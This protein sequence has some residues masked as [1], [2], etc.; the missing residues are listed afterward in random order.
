MTTQ[1]DIRAPR[2]EAHGI[3][4]RYG[5]VEA[6]KGVTLTVGRGEILCLAG[7]NGSGK[8]TFSK[9][10]AGTETSD[11]GSFR[12]D[13][14]VIDGLNQKERMQA[15]IQMIYQDFSLFHNLTAAENIYLVK[16]SCE[17][18][19]RINHQIGR[20]EAMVALESIGV[21]INPDALVEDL[22]VGEKQ[23]VAI[24]RAIIQNAKLI[25]MDEPTTALTDPEINQLMKIVR[26][27]AAQGVSFISISHKLEEILNLTDRTVILRGGSL[28]LEADTETLDEH[29]ITRALIGRELPIA[30]LRK[31][32]MK[33]GAPLLE[34]RGLRRE[35][36]FG[37]IDLTIEQGEIVGLGGRLG[38]GRTALALAL[39]GALR[40]DGG[41]FFLDG[42]QVNI[43]SIPDALRR[44]IAYL[45]EDRLTEGLFLENSIAENV[46]IPVLPKEAGRLGAL[47]LRR[48]RQLS[49]EWVRK[50]DIA[51]PSV[52]L[53]ARSLSGGNQQRVVLA[54]WLMNAPRLLILNR[55]TVGVDVGSK[56]ALHE[57]IREVAGQG[58]GVL[59]ISDDPS[60][61]DALSDRRLLVR[62]GQIIGEVESFSKQRV[63]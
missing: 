11:S 41:E 31:P 37:P 27:L 22:V 57:V 3:A 62:G 59:V 19:N 28:V 25:I 24:A 12:F 9:C 36:H 29:K 63:S 2:L 8:S 1:T 23:S 17:G 13:G 10:L 53:L 15:G 61:L 32:R 58:V 14:V 46:T 18:R 16:Q 54:K 48:L 5:G 56:F 35:G 26:R 20:Q 6:L 33:D 30:K 47:N 7:E 40:P 4:K 38:A 44:A 49:Q 51:T 55:P 43:A 21:S 42:K 34:L 39:F 50:L 52:D 60:E 45:P